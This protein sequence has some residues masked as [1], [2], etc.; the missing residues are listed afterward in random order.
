MN[1]RTYV[2]IPLVLAGLSGCRDTS[3][4]ERP[5]AESIQISVDSVRLLAAGDSVRL[6][7]TVADALGAPLPDVP[8]EW[9]SS[10]TTIAR[11]SGI[12]VV[13]AVGY[14]SAE[15]RASAMQRSAQV[16]V[17]VGEAGVASWSVAH[18][19][20]ITGEGLADVWTDP[21]GNIFAVGR[22]GTVI[23]FDGQSWSTL[24]AG[25]SEDLWRV[26][27]SS[28]S[29]LYVVAGQLARSLYDS[30]P[31]TI[32]HFDGSRWT[33]VY[34]AGVGRSL[35]SIWVAPGG[36]VF[37]VGLDKRNNW[38]RGFLAHW[39]GTAWEDADFDLS[40]EYVAM[41][42]V[43]GSSPSDVYAV[44]SSSSIGII[45]HFDGTSW[46]QVDG[47]PTTGAFTT[48]G[49]SGPN[50]VWAAGV[51]STIAHF[52]GE[53]WSVL[54]SP[55]RIWATSVWSTSATDAYISGY[56]STA[57]STIVLHYDGTRLTQL[58]TPPH[59]FS[60]ALQG[61]PRSP[62]ESYLVSNDG[63]VLRLAGG[64]WTTVQYGPRLLDVSG[65]DSGRVVAVGVTGAVFVD[66]GAEWV[67]ADPP[68]SAGDLT[69]LLPRS[70]GDFLVV[71]TG[72][73][74]Y[75]FDGEAWRTV[76]EGYGGVWTGSWGAPDGPIFVTKT[77]H[78]DSFRE[79]PPGWAR[80]IL[81][82][83]TD[84]SP[85]TVW[86]SD[87]TAA[88]QSIQQ[89][90]GR[91]ASEAYAV[92][93]GGFILR[94]DGSSWEPVASGTDRDLFGVGGA[95]DAFFAV[96]DGGLILRLVDGNWSPMQSGTSATLRAVWGSS[97]SNVYAVGD[98]GTILRFDGVR[99]SS[100]ATGTTARLNSV[101]GEDGS[102]FVAGDRAVILT[103]DS[104]RS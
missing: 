66:N 71:A 52:D 77:L 37:A 35:G 39:N 63:T 41:S 73:S 97:E 95:G 91:S 36:E 88:E 40:A 74:L 57:G 47:V 32:L 58:L 72:G 11:V 104:P 31:G 24:D 9:S 96:G 83:A 7:V 99:W 2:L 14:G 82:L 54:Q 49:G 20:G 10:D 4:P 81:E 12:G 25:T 50:D 86:M 78:R 101:W 17:T 51:E 76:S 3:G 22:A 29:N 48:V 103:G 61:T 94:F 67:Q 87:W 30:G 27:G 1:V 53:Q 33:T 13:V 16:D 56:S 64:S 59:V 23:R 46:R 28:S 70:E 55:I 79:T 93:S 98:D 15:I 26:S 85:R 62:S 6:E 68:P 34:T 43:W 65:T 44:G 89:V 5:A 19:G 90:A 102:V 92:G 80:S 42:G 18:A 60:N 21:Q 69:S 100:M 75:R 38:S 84:G 45:Y 8:V